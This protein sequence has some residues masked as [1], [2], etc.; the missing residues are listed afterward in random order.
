MLILLGIVG[1]I[2]IYRLHLAITVKKVWR[3]IIWW[4]ATASTT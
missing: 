1:K 2:K 3:S 4:K